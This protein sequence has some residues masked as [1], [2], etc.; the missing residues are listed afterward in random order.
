LQI[1]NPPYVPTPDDEVSKPGIAQAWA[2]GH[3][4]RVVMDRLLKEV[5]DI[6]PLMTGIMKLLLQQCLFISL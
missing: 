4:G 1:F 6:S 3:Q 2:G 5:G